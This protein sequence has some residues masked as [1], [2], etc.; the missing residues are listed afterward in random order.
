MSQAP[1]YYQ[2]INDNEIEIL[3]FRSGVAYDDFPYPEYPEYFAE[4]FVS[5]VALTAEEQTVIREIN[6]GRA[7]KYSVLQKR[8]DLCRPGHQIGGEPFLVQPWIESPC[9]KCATEMPFLASIG[10]DSG[11]ER[12]FTGNMFVQTIFNLCTSC[13]IIGAYQQSD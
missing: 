12:G 4:R 7:D 3:A 11:S 1:C 13:R 5:L 8:S 10:D 2:L 6:A 9:P